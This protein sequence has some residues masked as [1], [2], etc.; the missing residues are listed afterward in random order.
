MTPFVPFTNG[1]RGEVLFAFAGQSISNRFWLLSRFDPP[2][3]TQIDEAATGLVQWATDWLMPY[4]GADFELV[5]AR[6]ADW[7]ASPS[8]YTAVSSVSVFGGSS[9]NSHSAN[10]AYRVLIQGSSAQTWK[11]NSSFV[12]GIPLDIITGNVVD[13]SFR[14]AVFEAYVAL[15]DATGGWSAGNIWR[16]VVG[17]SWLNGTLRD[18]LAFARTDFIFTTD[19]YSTQR[20]R[21]T[22]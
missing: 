5:G 10:I 8:P 20:R 17:S 21:R 7:S 19:V 22:R 11:N 14:S 9:S 3:S 2:T 12:S 4:L 6:V 18:E 15:I 16:W 13:P 1:A